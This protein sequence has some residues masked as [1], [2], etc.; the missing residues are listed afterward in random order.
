MRIFLILLLGLFILPQCQKRRPPKGEYKVR[1]TYLEKYNKPVSEFTINIGESSKDWILI[2][3]ILEDVIYNYD[4]LFKTKNEIKGRL[5][6]SHLI[7]TISRDGFSPH[8]KIVGSFISYKQSLS[9][10]T[11]KYLGTF[12]IKKK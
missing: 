2:P 6:G 10:G 1:Y 9:Q 3:Y 12:E 8:F 4:T 7:G 5:Y 11:S